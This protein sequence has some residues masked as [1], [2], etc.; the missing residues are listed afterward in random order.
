MVPQVGQVHPSTIF[1][2]EV[3]VWGRGRGWQSNVNLTVDMLTAR[4]L[5]MKTVA[6][7]LTMPAMKEERVRGKKTQDTAA[8]L[9][10][11]L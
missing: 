1:Y 5:W 3:K 9:R 7:T 10:R 2:Q 8:I 11:E 4:A 6:I